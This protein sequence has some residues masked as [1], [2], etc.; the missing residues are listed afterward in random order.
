M[1]YI[2]TH[3]LERAKKG[4]AASFCKPFIL[5][6]IFELFD[7]ELNAEVCVTVS[8]GET[9]GRCSWNGLKVDLVGFRGSG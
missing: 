6:G 4:S 8:G 9:C 7:C 3:R 1:H 5:L 2:S